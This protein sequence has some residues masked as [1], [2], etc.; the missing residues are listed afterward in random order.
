MYKKRRNVTYCKDC[1]YFRNIGSFDEGIGYCEHLKI[2]RKD[3]YY[4]SDAE[5]KIKTWDAVTWLES[6]PEDIP[7]AKENLAAR[8]YYDNDGIRSLL[9]AVSLKACA[10]YKDAS[11]GL[12]VDKQPPERT[13]KECHTFFCGEV[14]SMFIGNMT[15][16]EA[17]KHI[18]DTPNGALNSIW[19]Q[20]K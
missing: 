7:L 17:E 4:C 5:N 8:E 12:Y 15:P 11:R 9:A 10:D 1:I 2:N 13:M 3:D 14:F 20:R 6:H 19:K 18:K 16:E